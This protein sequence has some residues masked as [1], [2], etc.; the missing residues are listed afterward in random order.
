M[1]KSKT[2]ILFQVPT[3]EYYELL[4]LKGTKRSW[5]EFFIPKLLEENN[6]V[7]IDVPN[8]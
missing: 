4:K 7:L 8:S 6:I 1:D 2:S 5:Y 3:N